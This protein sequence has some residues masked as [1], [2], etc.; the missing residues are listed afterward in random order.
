MHSTMKVAAVLLGGIFLSLA[1]QA[2]ATSTTLAVGDS[3]TVGYV[4]PGV[5]FGDSEI[6]GYV[7]PFVTMALGDSQ[8]ANYANHDNT[9]V[10]SLN[11]FPLTLVADG[12]YP[13]HGN[14]TAFNIVSGNE[15]LVAKY[16]G[17]NGGLEVWYIG[18][19]SGHINIPATA[20][21]TLFGQPSDNQFG[22]SGTWVLNGAPPGVPTPPGVPDG[23]ATVLLLGAALTG[24]GMLRRKLN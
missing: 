1:P 23:G 11:S 8:N 4:N 9:W 21:G 14:V 15:Y 6:P 17:P 22:L 16:D 2:Q 12:G 10:R 20:A 19:L 24:L 18:N 7:N 5:D 13:S 3:H